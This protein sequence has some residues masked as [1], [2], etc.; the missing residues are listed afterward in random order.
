MLARALLRST[1]ATYPATL[2]ALTV[3]SPLLSRSASSVLSTSTPSRTLSASSLVHRH[4]SSSSAM[5]A[6]FSFP[7]TLNNGEMKAFPLGDGTDKSVLL[8]KVQGTVYATSAKCTHYGAPL[9][10]GTLTADGRITCPWHGACFSAKTGDIE[11]APAMQCLQTFKT[12]VEGDQVIVELS[13]DALTNARAIPDRGTPRNLNGPVAVVLG[14]GAGGQAAA[15]SLR[16][17]GFKGRV[18]VYGKEPYLAVDRTKLSKG[19]EADAAKLALRP[20]DYYKE[21][22]IELHLGEEV[23]GVDF[24]RKQVTLAGGKTQDYSYIVIAA[25]SVPR[26]LDVPG[27]NLQNVH[28]LRSVNDANSLHK[29]IKSLDKPNVVIIGTGFI[30]MELASVLA[31][32]GKANVTIMANTE[33]PMKPVLGDVVGKFI[34][35]WHQTNGVKFI[36]NVSP[37]EFRA[38]EKDTSKVGSIALDNGQIIPADVVL[39][40]VGAIPATQ[41]LKSSSLLNDDGSISVNKFLH[42]DSRPEVYVCGDVAKFPVSESKTVRVEHWNV[43]RNTARLAA[44]N[45]ALAAAAT[46]AGTPAS[47]ILEPFTKVPYFWSVQ[48]GKSIRYAGALPFDDVYVDGDIESK[49]GEDTSFAAYYGLKGKVVAVASLNKDPVV[50][51]FSELVRLGLCPSLSEIKGGKDI[52]SVPL[53]PASQQK[54]T[55]SL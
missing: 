34:K 41:N 54:T 4:N 39:V 10:K 12:H 21:R 38:S 25:G 5:P 42:V 48:Y 19:L 31:K 55:A 8:S 9:E 22:D 11:D 15:E 40:A 33:I 29:S 52:L 32:D 50:S 35:R 53:G 36:D 2:S 17:Y 45:I 37:K 27:A 30:G 1:L 47:S 20:A 7:N 43:A 23:T 51:Q 14:N 49:K 28:V 18:V 46:E 26:S 44:K 3:P 6:Q 24:D 16:E 13:P